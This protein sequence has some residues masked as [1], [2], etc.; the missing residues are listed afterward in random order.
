MRV[1][2]TGAAGFI[3]NCVARKLLDQGHEV[4]TIDNFSF[5]KREFLPEGVALRELD[6]GKA[7]A[8]DV[9]DAVTGFAPDRIIHLAAIHFIPYCMSHPDETFASNVRGTELI[10][11]AAQESPATKIVMAS[12]MDVYAPVDKIHSEDDEPLPC[13]AYGLSKWLGENILACAVR[14]NDKLSA[15][16]LRFANAFGP[17]ETN[18]HLIPDALGYVKDRSNP[19]IRMGY[20]GAERDFVHVSDVANAVVGCALKDTGR[21]NV[22]NI[23]SGVSTEVRKVVQ[24]IQAYAG[25]TRPVIED[26]RKLR[27]F[28]R[29]TLSPDTARIRAAIGWAPEWDL[30]AGIKDLVE[31]YV[32]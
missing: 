4:S 15:T 17:N 32:L 3:G 26:P 18:A 31:R 11:R 19:E 27:K 29:R 25:D 14:T 12:T 10:V 9:I 24:L 1:L 21:Y 28:D 8:G 13:N 30:E 6:I 7:P 2:V 5:G 16:A 22:F 23:G 20:M